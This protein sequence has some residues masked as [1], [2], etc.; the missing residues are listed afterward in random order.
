[1]VYLW[2]GAA[3]IQSEVIKIF[4]AAL[5]NG[6]L[7]ALLL[8]L[9][10]FLLVNLIRKAYSYVSHKIS[11]SRAALRAGMGTGNSD[12]D[13]TLEIAGYAYDSQQDIF[14][15]IMDP[16]QR[17]FGYCRLYDE[18]AAP[19]NMIIDCEPIYFEYDSKRWLI[20][21]W[22]G[23]YALTT[24]CELG[25]YT[26]KG[27]DLN[28]P[29]VFNGTFYNCASNED[30]LYMSCVL[31]KNS[32]TL[33]KREGKHWWLTG[34]ILG[35]FSEPAELVMLVNITLKDKA[36]RKAFVKG[37]IN[38]GYTQNEVSI[39]GNTVSFTFDKPKTPQPYTRT[40]A[41][42]WI[43]QRKNELLC[44]IYQEVTEGSA[45]IEE[46]VRAIQHNAPGVYEDILNMGK[47]KQLYEVYS[48]IR[49]Y[50]NIREQ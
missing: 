3:L 14:Y 33:F 20:Q 41:T 32:G 9:S 37:L 17:N 22:K 26:T 45:T 49:K 4:G 24:G 27:P 19:L 5:E 21:L 44:S 13:K 28:I 6:G 48:L 35:E 39:R 30:F 7:Y 11:K 31:Q 40:P 38:A 2:F 42:D 1:M 8:I 34:F 43:I 10:A 50:L 25:I 12:L 47:S 23:Q 46:K 36:M 18:A 29:G 16:W 15:S